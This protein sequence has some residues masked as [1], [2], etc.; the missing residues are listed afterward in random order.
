MKK[1]ILA[2]LAVLM[3][4][5][6][7]AEWTRIGG[8]DGA[9]IYVDLETFRRNGEKVK[10]WYLQNFKTPNGITEITRLSDKS[11]WELD[12]KEDQIKL[13]A[14][15]E[16][17]GRNGTGI[18]VLSAY[19]VA[20][21]WQ[22]SIPNTIG[23]LLFN[24]GCLTPIGANKWTYIKPSEARAAS[25]LTVNSYLDYSSSKKRGDIVSIWLLQDGRSENPEL[26]SKNFSMKSQREFNCKKGE[27]RI[28]NLMFFPAN[29]G[30]GKSSISSNE[31]PPSAWEKITGSTDQDIFKIVCDS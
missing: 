6:A 12:C 3:S 21:T 23:E 19:K 30:V 14:Y 13:L 29:M 24:A 1:I 15:I 17:A 25:D 8:D 7:A 20:N 10:L 9:D 2:L 18:V 16:Y 22:P 31:K 11:Q 4:S 5:S 27:S 28:V 26:A